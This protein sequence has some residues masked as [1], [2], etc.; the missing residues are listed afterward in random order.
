MEKKKKSERDKRVSEKK[1]E[2]LRKAYERRIEYDIKKRER[3]K[4]T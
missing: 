3:T 1:R 2:K 4:W